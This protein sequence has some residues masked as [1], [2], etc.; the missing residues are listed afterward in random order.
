MIAQACVAPDCDNQDCGSC[1][2]ACCKLTFTFPPSMTSTD[3]AT[4][5]NNTIMGGGPDGRY[6][7]TTLAEGVHNV[8]DLHPLGVPVYIAKTIHTTAK[9]VYNDSIDMTITDSAGG[10]TLRAFSISQVGGAY[11]DAG[12][13]FKNIVTLIKPV[14]EKLGLNFSYAHVD[15]SCPPPS[16]FIQ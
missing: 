5:L 9:R 1:A 6:F 11:C 14:Y 15:D 3:V 13:N 4:V 8:A 2:N 12:Q 10:A 16:N 7:E